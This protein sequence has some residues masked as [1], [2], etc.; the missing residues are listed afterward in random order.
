MAF[1]IILVL[2][3]AFTIITARSRAMDARRRMHIGEDR[4]FEERRALAAY[5]QLRDMSF[6]RWSG[7]LTLICGVLLIA[8]DIM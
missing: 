4:F 7:W 2:A 6:F 5:P 3:G 8:K 1:G